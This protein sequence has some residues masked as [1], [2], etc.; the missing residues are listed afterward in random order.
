[1]ATTATAT[2]TNQANTA[3]ATANQLLPALVLFA[4]KAIAGDTDATPE[5]LNGILNGYSYAELVAGHAK[6]TVRAELATDAGENAEPYT[7][8]CDALAFKLRER[9]TA[10]RAKLQTEGIGY[11]TRKGQ[12]F[13]GKGKLAP[14]K[15]KLAPEGK[16]LTVQYDANLFGRIPN[17]GV[18]QETIKGEHRLTVIG[19]GGKTAG[20]PVERLNAGIALL[21]ATQSRID[22]LRA[23]LGG[24]TDAKFAELLDRFNGSDA[25]LI[26]A[27]LNRA[28]AMTREGKPVTFETLRPAPKSK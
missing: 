7:V 28:D 3:T 4:Q 17:W 25:Q 1:M 24:I 16:Y 27:I 21:M 19:T 23:K 12:P 22:A 13:A 20:D 14:G 9:D 6:L 8:A 26:L 5:L 11:L 18:K 10:I 2:A 15:G